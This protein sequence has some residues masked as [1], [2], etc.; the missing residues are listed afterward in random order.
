MSEKP[1]REVEEAGSLLSPLGQAALAYA[2]QGIPVFPCEPGEKAPLFL[3]GAAEAT[4]DPDQIRAWWAQHPDANIGG[5]MRGMVM[6][7][8]SPTGDAEAAERLAQE[9]TRAHRSPRD[10]I[11]YLF[12]TEEA[13]PDRAE[14][15][16]GIHV[17]CA[18]SYVL[19]PTSVIDGE[20]EYVVIK[21]AEPAPLPECLAARLRAAKAPKPNMD[22]PLNYEDWLRM[23]DTPM[24]IDQLVPA[25]KLTIIWGDTGQGKT[26][27]LAELA[28]AIAWRRP[29]FGR[30]NVNLPRRGGVVVIFAGEDAKELVKSRLTALA[31]KYNRSVEGRIYVA[32]VALPVDDDEKLKYLK[33]KVHDIQ[34]ASGRPIDAILNDTLGRSLGSKSPNDAEVAQYFSVVME[35]LTKEFGCAVI[36]TAHQPKAGG[37][38]AGSQIFV[39]NAP[40]TIHVE[41]DFDTDNQLIGF[42][43]KFAPKYRIGPTPPRF[44]VIA[45]TVTLPWASNNNR[46]D[47][48]FRMA[49]E[50][51]ADAEGK[52]PRKP[53]AS[54]KG[55]N[56]EKMLAAIQ[57]FGADGASYSDW[58]GKSAVPPSSFSRNYR[59]LIDD[60]RVTQTKTPDGKDLF[61]WAGPKTL[62]GVA[63][64]AGE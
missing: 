44:R 64:A 54:G 24:V 9:Q 57:T 45:E 40:V 49:A 50:P 3:R 26:Y 1:N 37:T 4:T 27:L 33:G 51:E 8:V 59:K 48:V 52:A 39:N 61:V 23:P 12:R 5:Q 22:D 15:W 32:P 31:V 7:D 60:E 14:P 20:G 30:F 10:G 47:I 18:G 16:E 55:L 29:A 19:L 35:G 28:T 6:I 34:R 17:R 2:E 58:Q 56:L 25:E 21:E 11:H 41:G 42:S 36:C 53:K 62:G 38:I 46:T 63:E 43:N 13:F